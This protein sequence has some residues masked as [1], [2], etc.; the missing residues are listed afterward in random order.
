ME[1]LR[2]HFIFPPHPPGSFLPNVQGCTWHTTVVNDD[3]VNDG[4]H[5]VLLKNCGLSL[6]NVMDDL[7]C[8][9]VHR[10]GGFVMGKEF[11]SNDFDQDTTFII[12]EVD[13]YVINDVTILNIECDTYS[14]NQ[15]A[16]FEK[17]LKNIAENRFTR[18]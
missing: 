12:Q 18:G 3:I 13:E 4:P 10:R 15:D 2:N 8:W 11:A 5:Y 14:K 9:L 6:G 1:K 16:G 17:F 7:S